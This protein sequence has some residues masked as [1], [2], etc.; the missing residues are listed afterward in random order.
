MDA[1]S[2]KA[3]RPNR[4]RV[5]MIYEIKKKAQSRRRENKEA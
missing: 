2:A 1:P 4:N 5:R 3:K